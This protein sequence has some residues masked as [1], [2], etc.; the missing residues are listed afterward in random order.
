[1]MIR[2]STRFAALGLAAMLAIG[3]DKKDEP[4]AAPASTGGSA[5]PV[6]DS[7]KMTPTMAGA[8]DQA[9]KTAADVT[10]KSNDMGA[11]AKDAGD[12][13]VT[14]AQKLYDDAK[15]AM[16]KADFAGAQK[17]VDQLS[18]LKSKLPADWQTKVTELEKM[19]A[20][21]KAKMGAMPS[22]PKMGQ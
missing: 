6:T 9:A 11:A 10:A 20:D 8:Q 3:C 5:A 16:N 13:M 22:L 18:A 4:M 1:M 2:T 21:G 12:S 17:Y 15:A 14:Q 19:V 7:T